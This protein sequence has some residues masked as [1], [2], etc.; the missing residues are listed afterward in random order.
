MDEPV[1]AHKQHTHKAFYYSIV[2]IYST[3]EIPLTRKA[4]LLN[5]SRVRT[6]RIFYCPLRQ[7][8]AMMMNGIKRV[9]SPASRQTTESSGSSVTRTD[10]LVTQAGIFHAALHPPI[11]EDSLHGE[12]KTNWA[13]YCRSF[14]C[15]S[16]LC[17]PPSSGTTITNGRRGTWPMLNYTPELDSTKPALSPSPLDAWL[18]TADR[19]ERI[20]TGGAP[21]D[22]RVIGLGA[23]D[24]LIERLPG[25]R[26]DG[27]AAQV[28]L[29][30]D[31]ATGTFA[32]WR[33]KVATWCCA[34]ENRPAWENA[35]G[36]L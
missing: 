20:R 4:R 19:L 32:G 5:A 25:V 8:V 28:T 34:G 29:V 14:S 36:A 24:G 17:N 16:S 3:A 30:F 9:C 31:E 13:H 23:L 2:S 21:V 15:S 12:R 1:I 10:R 27:A 7:P 33:P 35:W 26:K 6:P 22:T 18:A 11:P